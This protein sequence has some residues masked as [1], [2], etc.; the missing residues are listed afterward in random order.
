MF[1]KVYLPLLGMALLL[2]LLLTGCGCKH[3]WK[4]ATCDTPKTCAKC[5]ET[6]GEALGHNWKEATCETAKTCSVCNKMSGD[7]LGHNWVD[8]T[9][10]TPKTCSVCQKTEG[11]RI[12][13]DSRF[14]TEKCKFLFGTWKFSTYIMGHRADLDG[15]YVKIPIVYQIVFNPDGTCMPTITLQDEKSLLPE[16]EE[17][18]KTKLLEEYASM[19]L[20]QA[21]IDAVVLATYGM[22]ANAYA[23]KQA[24]SVDW[25]GIFASMATERVYYVENSQTIKKIYMGESW[26]G[27]KDFGYVSL[28]GSQLRIS[29]YSLIS[30][31][32]QTLVLDRVSDT[33]TK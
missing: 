9:T 19:N 20:T 5:S 18:F 4:D 31:L 33:P 16:L 8:A 21:Q 28:M 10:E 25:E 23:K 14:K 24:E 17:Y 3:E 29:P 15:C 22:D 13:T 11:D 30:S 26:G 1:K 32:N 2:S 6:E 27:K 12:I 7:A